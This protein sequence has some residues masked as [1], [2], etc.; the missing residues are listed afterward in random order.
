M[1]ICTSIRNVFLGV[2]TLIIS[3]A[4][5]TAFTQ[6][7]S[8]NIQI[9]DVSA[10][11]Y[12]SLALASNGTVY[13]FGGNYN[14]QMGVDPAI[15]FASTPVKIPKLENITAISSGN[16]HSMALDKEGNVWVWGSNNRGQMGDG[17]FTE[18]TRAADGRVSISVNHDRTEPVKVAGL[19]AITGIFAG[20]DSCFA[21]TTG[22]EVY[23]WGNSYLNDSSFRTRRAIILGHEDLSFE[24][25]RLSPYK[26]Q[27]LSNVKMISAEHETFFAVDKDGSVWAWG[28]NNAAAYGISFPGLQSGNFSIS[29]A[30]I[31]TL[32][33]VS[34]I[35]QFIYAKKV[36]VYYN[37]ETAQQWGTTGELSPAAGFTGS[38]QAVPFGFDVAAITSKGNAQVWTIKTDQWGDIPL[39]NLKRISVISLSPIPSI[40]ASDEQG[41]LWTWTQSKGAVKFEGFGRADS[42]RVKV[43]VNGTTLGF[44]KNTPYIKND[45]LYLPMQ[46]IAKAA[47]IKLT[48]TN[49]K[50]AISLKMGGRTVAVLVGSPKIKVN[51]QEK[52]IKAATELISGTVMI[53][54]EVWRD[55]LGLKA[56]WDKSLNRLYIQTK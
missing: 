34:K 44:Q 49:F 16:E 40:I 18:L 11:Y 45:V 50:S 54:L 51:G 56:D 55:E 15:K 27:G 42:T 5:W 52:T 53:P 39:K 21:I 48:I 14:G 22:G 41:Q 36:V 29:P 7:A 23:A 28:I 6:A 1:N 4:G 2:L 12:H 9:V 47:G 17:T 13:S 38:Q 20:D 46:E 35:E 25:S 24:K 33:N 30:R 26:L 43:E 31:N 37:D 8:P 3:T 19:P 32:S 10:G